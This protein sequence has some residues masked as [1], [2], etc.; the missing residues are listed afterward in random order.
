MTH[1]HGESD[2]DRWLNEGGVQLPIS[3]AVLD[4]G[5]LEEAE[6]RVI[7]CLGAAIL[8][9]WHE[10]PTDV[11]RKVLQGALSSTTYDANALK[12]KVAVFLRG[13]QGSLA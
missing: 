7:A 5:I 2:I 10:M 6:R 4:P 3:V 9:V 11:R 8:S 13:R 1:D 12:A